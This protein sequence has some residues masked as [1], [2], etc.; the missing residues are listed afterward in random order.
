MHYIAIGGDVSKGRL[1]IAI[2]NQSQTTLFSGVYD[3][4]AAGHLALQQQLL[5]LRE[6]YPEALFLVGLESTGGLERN[7]LAFFR[8]ERKWTKVMQVHHLT[9]VQLKRFLSA[10]LHRS[11]T[12]AS[13]AVGIARYLLERLRDRPAQVHVASAAVHFYRTLRSVMQRRTEV[14]Q[15]LHAVLIQ[16]QPE[17]VQYCRSGFPDWIINLLE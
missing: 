6:R 16:I 7:W 14:E 15:Q 11:V 17:L 13:A 12:D 8:D 9:P 4:T 2:L 5:A 1:D 3:D 10:D